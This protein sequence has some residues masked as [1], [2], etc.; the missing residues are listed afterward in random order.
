MQQTTQQTTIK[1]ID[2]FAF[3]VSDPQ[4]AIAFYRDVF[5]MEPTDIDDEGRGAEFTLA[6]G[7]T[8]G[9]WK[10]EEGQAVPSGAA[11][12][13]V[14]DLQGAIATFR[15][16]GAKLSEPIESNVCFMSFGTD[17]DGNSVIIHK[18]KK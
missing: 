18:R 3:L 6:D 12:F 16:R 17:P 4:R 7:S 5:G 14:D 9:V 13:A 2:L 1:G 10:A 15:A 8:F 11:M